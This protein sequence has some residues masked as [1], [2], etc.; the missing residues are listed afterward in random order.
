MSQY[1]N[2]FENV[3]MTDDKCRA[4][5]STCY[6]MCQ[7]NSMYGNGGGR[8]LANNNDKNNKDQNQNSNGHWWNWSKWTS[9]NNKGANNEQYDET[10]YNSES[11]QQQQKEK[12]QQYDEE[13]GYNE[14]ADENSEEYQQYQ[15]AKAQ[16]YQN[17]DYS[18]YNGGN[19]QNAAH[20]G[21]YDGASANNGGNVD[22]ESYQQEV[23][24]SNNAEN[25]NYY[26]RDNSNW[27][28]Q[29][30]YG[31]YFDAEYCRMNC[32][33]DAGM[34]YCD[35]GNGAS[36]AANENAAQGYEYN[37][38]DIPS[39]V[40][41]HQL[42][43]YSSDSQQLWVGAACKNGGVYLE[44]FLDST[45]SRTAPKNT[46]ENAVSLPSTRFV[47]TSFDAILNSCSCS[48]LVILRLATHCLAKTW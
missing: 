17:V 2:A 3:V 35:G 14:D 4:Q 25:N 10:V 23:E 40:E 27:R 37:E 44:T 26:N 13:Y 12:Q 21:D 36:Q 7:G 46:H 47:F 15:Q 28:D 6:S 11:W 22:Y 31:N 20:N 29:D 1:V 39:L 16:Y 38:M 43:Y 19:Y 41:C 32:M 34:S 18:Q 5:Q 42:D 24:E 33:S 48:C 30:E 8:R 9:G 45:C